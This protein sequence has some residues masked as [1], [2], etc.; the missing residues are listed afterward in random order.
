MTGQSQAVLVRSRRF[1]LRHAT[2]TRRANVALARIA[3]R[4]DGDPITAV[5]AACLLEQA[6]DI[7]DGGQRLLDAL[8]RPTKVRLDYEAA[9]RAKWLRQQAAAGRSAAGSSDP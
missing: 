3:E 9:A 6:A 5:V 8:V 2:A 4:V 7:L 1:S